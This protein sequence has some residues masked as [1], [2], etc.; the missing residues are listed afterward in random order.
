LPLRAARSSVHDYDAEGTRKRWIAGGEG[1][2]RQPSQSETVS[3]KPT[4]SSVT[5]V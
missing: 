5:T 3:S 2:E 4:R 1:D